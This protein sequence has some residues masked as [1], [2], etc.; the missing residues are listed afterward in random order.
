MAAALLSAQARGKGYFPSLLAGFN[1]QEAQEVSNGEREML[2]EVR[3]G[4]W[5]AMLV[6]ATCL[7]TFRNY[8][9]T[10]QSTQGLLGC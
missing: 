3:A 4:D 10:R 8:K 6:A 9:E 1:V 5:D 2:W 7:R